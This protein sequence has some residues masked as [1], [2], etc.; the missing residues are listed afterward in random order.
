MKRRT[1]LLGGAAVGLGSSAQGAS[2]GR[3]FDAAR[4]EAALARIDARMRLLAEADFS[5]RA[6]TGETDA[7]LLA[8]RNRL[9]RAAA[10]SIYFTGAFLELEEHERLHPGVQLRLRRLEPEVDEAVDGMA[11]LIESLGPDD[12]R[13]LREAFQRDPNLKAK[14]GDVLQR[15][16]KE[17]GFGF[18]R[19]LD[20]RLA[21]DEMV[22]RL[23]AQNPALLLDPPAQKAR[24]IQAH[25]RTE[26]EQDRIL[27]I[28][29][30]EKGFW[31][32]QQRSAQ[33]VAQWDRIYSHRPAMYLAAIDDTYPAA[34][35][36]QDE[37]KHNTMISGLIVMGIG[38][39]IAGLGGI[40]YAVGATGPGVVMGITIGPLLLLIGLIILIVS[41]FM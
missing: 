4:V 3:R 26:A 34:R 40:L 16:A 30:G 39:G 6:P 1:L 35:S 20:L 27:A 28:R 13:S 33:A 31:E 17:D 29:L 19:R 24:R 9:G 11:T 7:E 36:P 2:G 21:V 23:Q 14:V 25:P 41:A 10:R 12:H 37:A 32:F 38:A 22:G 15:V 8:S 18:T 5:S